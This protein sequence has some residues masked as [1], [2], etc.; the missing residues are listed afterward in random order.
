M[1]DAGKFALAE[2]VA[3]ALAERGFAPGAAPG[4]DRGPVA[5]AQRE[6]R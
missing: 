6:S 1:D 5:E 3:E 4:V 2:I